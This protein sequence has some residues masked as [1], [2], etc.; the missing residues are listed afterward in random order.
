M[1]PVKF[2]VVV[3]TPIGLT[4]ELQKDLHTAAL[5]QYRMLSLEI[6]RIKGNIFR[7]TAFFHPEDVTPQTGEGEFFKIRDRLISLLSITAMVPVD[8]RSKGSFTFSLGDRKY[9]QMSLG[10]MNTEASPVALKSL[11]P[12]VEGQ[13]LPPKYAAA[14]YFIWQAINADESLY[15]FINTAICLE[16]LAGADSPEPT[17]I[18]PECGNDN[19]DYVLDKCP[20]CKRDWKI[21]NFLRKRAKFLI[22][23]EDLLAKFIK[24]RNKV[25]HGGSGQQDTSFLTELERV[26]IPVMLAVRNHIGHKIGLPLIDEKGLSIG[27]HSISVTMSVFYTIPESGQDAQNL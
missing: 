24:A 19:C 20:Q 13:S 16:L 26:S 15:R 3:E 12:L 22:P 9:Q 10:P 11:Q 27:F 17:S 4:I 2:E 6:N 21:P 7:L 18:N 14:I 8:L 23:D 25:F 1:E 5:P